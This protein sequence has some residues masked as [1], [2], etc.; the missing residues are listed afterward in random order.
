MKHPP[1]WTRRQLLAMAVALPVP[2]AF[3]AT[4]APVAPALA[5][6][7]LAVR[8][9]ERSVLLA[10]VLAGRRLVAVGEHGLVLLSD[11]D[12]ASWRQQTVPV[13]VTLT[14]VRFF[15]D[16]HGAAVGHG[17]T[18]LLSADGGERW[19]LALDGRRAADLALAAARTGQDA[20]ALRNAE[21]LVAEG[22]DKPF[23]DVLMASPSEI[24][25]V[26]AYGLAFASADGGRSWASWMDR[27][28]NPKGL[29][30]Y[31]L[32]RSGDTLAIAGEQGLVLRSDDA[33]RSFQRLETPYKG[34]FF[35]AEL[36]GTQDIVLAGLRG[37]AWRSRDGGRRWTQL[38][39]PMNASITSSLRAADGALLFG[40]QAGFVMRLAGDRLET[41]NTAALPPINGLVAGT[42]QRLTALTPMGALPLGVSTS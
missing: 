14:S 7:A 21:R 40:N 28:P 30:G 13:S 39:V 41:V 1:T 15:D 11:D 16:R 20:A 18:V 3:A 6:P 22:A 27:L 25:A 38:Q 4:A 29:H 23:L 17:G 19:T 2:G 36:A 26:G 12:G 9:A 35:T 24:V 10:A 8:R 5:R 33:G 34:S 42:R 31:A 37:N 32:R